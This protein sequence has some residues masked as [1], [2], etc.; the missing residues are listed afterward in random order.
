MILN[1]LR[2][3]NEL[4]EFTLEE[5]NEIAS[6]YFTVGRSRNEAPFVIQSLSSFRKKANSLKAAIRNHKE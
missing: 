5:I 1:E 3:L 4:D 6:Y 2:L